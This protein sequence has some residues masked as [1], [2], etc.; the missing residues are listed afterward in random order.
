MPLLAHL[1]IGLASKRFAPKIPLWILIFSAFWIDIVSVFFMPLKW[2]SHGLMMAI[3]WTSVGMLVTYVV[4]KIKQKKNLKNNQEGIKTKI[5]EYCI[6]IGIVI[7]SHWIL[8][9]IGWPM[10][11]ILPTWTGVPILF[12]D[13]FNFGL[14]VYSTW[15]GAI[16]M[17]LGVL[18][19]GIMVYLKS[20]KIKK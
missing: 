18:I 2:P 15:I 13:S 10:T 4:L 12:N 19:I 11:V 8:D 9:F 5:S 6:P 7:F 1:G 3:V 17:D 16:I 14:G 20:R